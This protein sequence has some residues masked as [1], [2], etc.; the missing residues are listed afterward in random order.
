MNRRYITTPIYYVNADPHIGHAHTSTM[1]DVLKKMS[2]RDGSEVFMTT[3]TDEHGQKNQ[4]AAEKSGLGITHYLDQQSA[5]FR[6][7][8]DRLGV[9]YDMWVRTTHESHK[10]AVRHVLEKLFAHGVLVKKRYE[11]LYCVGC[12]M[13]KKTSD[14]D[15]AGRCP[16]HL[17]APELLTEENYFLRLSLHQDWLVTFLQENPD[18]IQPEQYRN[19]VLGML[20]EPLDDM[21]ISRPKS[22][23]SLGVELPFDPGFVAYVW[24]DALINY[25]SNLGWP[26][27]EARVEAW[28]PNAVHLMAKDIIKT[29]CIYWPIMLRALDVPMPRRCLV[30]GYWVGEGNVKMSKTIGNV[31]V[32][33]AV[34]DTFSADT[35]RFY[36]ARNMRSSDSPISVELVRRCHNGD[37]VN[38]LGNLYSRVVKLTA[39][40]YGSAVPECPELHDEDQALLDSVLE[41]VREG[42]GEFSFSAV[43]QLAQR[44]LDAADLTNRHVNVTA[45][46]ELAKD[47]E[48]SERVVS[49]L[50]ACLESVRLIFEAGYPLLPNT[51]TR[52]LNNMNVPWT[53]ETAKSWEPE[54]RAISPGAMLGEDTMLF[55]RVRDA[56]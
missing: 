39:R 27:D 21:C 6:A 37:L 2:Q 32:P 51:A 30:H 53:A 56:G 24:F 3:G 13:F 25:L 7:A 42:R 38:N 31:V 26:G 19:E 41:L 34:V 12:E 45:P 15:E 18:W 46:W 4:D 48:S 33:D 10:A 29:H 28:W 22:R 11:G 20:S 5:R 44:I 16:D 14:L 43:T 55:E 54:A 47:P 40:D 17:A 23:V 49:V 1:A 8:F 35:L 9:E 36:L 52:A 50:V